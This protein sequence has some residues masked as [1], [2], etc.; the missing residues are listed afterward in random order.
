MRSWCIIF[1]TNLDRGRTIYLYFYFFYLL[2]K[3]LPIIQPR[4][5]PLTEKKI[6]LIIRSVTSKNNSLELTN[7][8]KRHTKSG[9]NQLTRR[10]RKHTTPATG[11]E[12]NEIVTKQPMNTRD[13]KTAT[14]A[15]NRPPFN[16]YGFSANQ[17]LSV[18]N[19]VLYFR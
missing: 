7:D 2:F 3:I 9:A 10:N 8:A 6:K 17:V 15:P 18:I 13:C 5:A 16:Q 19:L 11:S 1:K 4:S 12:V 14:M